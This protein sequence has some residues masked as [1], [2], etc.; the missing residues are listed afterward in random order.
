MILFRITKLDTLAQIPIDA[1][2]VQAAARPLSNILLN[3]DHIGRQHR[4]CAPK[5]ITSTIYNEQIT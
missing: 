3:D 4:P 2:F 1:S 5:R